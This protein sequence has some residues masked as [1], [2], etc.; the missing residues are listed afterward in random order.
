MKTFD[1]GWGE[2]VA[3]REAFVNVAASPVV[4]GVKA[5]NDLGYPAHEGD[6]KL[7]E[8]T[9]KIIKRQI[10]LDYKYILITNGATGALNIALRSYML[11]AG[12]QACFTRK[13]PFFRYYP[14]IIRNAHMAHFQGLYDS[15]AK[16]EANEVF[17][18][19]RVYLVDSLSNPL[20]QMHFCPKDL[21]ENPIIWDAVYYGNVYAPGIK[22]T[23]EHDVL[24][25]SY[26]K[27]TGLNGLRVGWIAVNDTFL[28]DRMRRLVT[29]EYCG[30][31]AA[32][33]KII[34]ETAGKFTKTDW[35]NFEYR[36]VRNLDDNR[37]EMAKLEKYFGNTPVSPFG[38]FYYGP[39]DEACK[40]LMQKS[41]IIWSPGSH[42]GDTDDFGR[43]N[44]GQDMKLVKEA[45]KT[46]L[47]NDKI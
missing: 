43:L 29:P 21:M 26:S 45:V 38:M 6:A 27:F 39:M 23:P 47:K 28:Y 33:T 10:G 7:I 4:F 8:L 9:R 41:G 5:L 16:K 44:V 34:L 22:A 31:S 35:E 24:V 36:A 46:V 30:I 15:D 42:L 3:V 32:S 25:G 14:A 20:G 17:G 2:S 1:L 12:I 40:A 11:S 13:A 18:R 37:N 19:K